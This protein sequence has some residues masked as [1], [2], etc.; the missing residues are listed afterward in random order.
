MHRSEETCADWCSGW[1]QLNVHVT[2]VS[3]LPTY[4]NNTVPPQLISLFPAT[5]G[6]WDME[7]MCITRNR[8]VNA[9]RFQYLAS[10]LT[11]TNEF[12]TKI[13]RTPIYGPTCTGRPSAPGLWVGRKEKHWNKTFWEELIA[14]FPWYDTGHIENASNNSSIFACVFVT[15]VTFLPSRCLATIGNFYRAVA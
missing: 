3:G 2:T 14:Y 1:K 15:A 11:R 10:I 6:T 8:F 5:S 4:R 9:I 7:L 13:K 12:C